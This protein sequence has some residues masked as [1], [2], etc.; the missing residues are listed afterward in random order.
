MLLVRGRVSDS[1]LCDALRA[2]APDAATL[3]LFV[4]DWTCDGGRAATFHM[5]AVMDTLVRAA[6]AHL[7]H[8]LMR[9]A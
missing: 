3:S 8:T 4:T 1:P 9:L 2:D 6:L 7:A 5:D